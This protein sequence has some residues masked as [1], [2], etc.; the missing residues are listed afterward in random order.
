M[1]IYTYKACKNGCNIC[2]GGFELLQRPDQEKKA[3]CPYCKAK[4]KRVFSCFAIKKSGRSLDRRAKE[5]GF[6]K[7]KKVDKGKYEKIY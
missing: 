5:K 2:E 1:P 4:I 6:H 3:V 7:L